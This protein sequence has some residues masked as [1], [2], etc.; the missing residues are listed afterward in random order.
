MT[1]HDQKVN[2]E[3]DELPESEICPCPEEYPDW[4][5]KTINLGGCCVHEMK[6]AS[7]FHMPMAYDMYVSKQAANVEHLGLVEK[8]PGFLMT[9]TGMWGGR[10]MRLLEDSE[11]PSRLVHYLP[12]PFIVEVKLHNGGVGSVPKAVHKMQIEMVEKGRMPKDLYLAHLTCPYCEERKQGD[13]IMILRKFTANERVMLRLEEERRREEQKAADK[14]LKEGKN[15]TIQ[16]K[17]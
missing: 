1:E 10:I 17:E 8:W 4:D 3:A 7:F 11:S 9:K 16:T 14:S 15:K 6:I 12:E 2:P 13:K 5:G